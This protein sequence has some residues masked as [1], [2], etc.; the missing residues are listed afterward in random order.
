MIKYF[1]LISAIAISFET[2][3]QQVVDTD[4]LHSEPSEN[5]QVFPLYS[6]SLYSSF[7]ITVE[8]SVAL[9]YHEYHTEQIFVIEGEGEMKLGDEYLSISE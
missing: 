6:D 9:H 1:F 5:I 8:D 2:I 7:I 4:T 3:G